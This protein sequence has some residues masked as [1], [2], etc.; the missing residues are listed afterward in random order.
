MDIEN[1]QGF[2]SDSAVQV[3]C[4]MVKGPGKSSSN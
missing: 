3:T 1:Y 2:S 4:P